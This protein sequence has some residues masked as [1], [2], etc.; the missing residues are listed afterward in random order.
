V[1]AAADALAAVPAPVPQATAAGNAAVNAA[2][3]RAERALL[4]P[5]GIPGR[6][7]F[8]H[9]VYAPLPSYEAETLPGVREAVRAGEM[10]RAR[11]QA[12]LLAAAL[13]RAAALLGSGA[14]EGGPR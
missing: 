9:L 13:R 4:E 6:P 1:T 8:R 5:A 3:M 11:E 12:A 14:S 7:W 2:L 10:A